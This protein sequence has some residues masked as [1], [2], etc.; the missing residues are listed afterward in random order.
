MKGKKYFAAA[1]LT[2]LVWGAGAP[3]ADAFALDDKGKLRMDCVYSIRY[4]HNEIDT[5]E[6][7]GHALIVDLHW[8]FAKNLSLNTQSEFHQLFKH[9][10]PWSTSSDGYF[11]SWMLPLYECYVQGDYKEHNLS[12]KVGQFTYMPAYGVSHGLYQEVYGAQV[13][14]GK[15]VKFTLAGGKTRPYWP[16]GQRNSTLAHDDGMMKKSDYFAADVVVPVDKNTNIRA[17][18]QHGAVPLPKQVPVNPELLNFTEI[19][20]DTK[21][22]KDFSLEAA[23]LHST[24]DTDNKGLYAKLQYKGIRPDKPGS[25][26][27]FVTYHDLEANSIMG[28][29]IPLKADQKGVRY[30]VHFVPVKNTIVTVWYD[31]AKVISTGADK[32]KFRAQL[33]VLF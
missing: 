12:A 21:I 1:L 26:D 6:D 27:V 28:N 9:D 32:D 22:A 19:G 18:W 33:D 8:N 30:G 20:F 7:W 10:L 3:S 14:Y 17:L 24:A 25:Y 13:T 23:A 16:G 29:D 4:D 5:V 11:H 15:T 2:S 31:D